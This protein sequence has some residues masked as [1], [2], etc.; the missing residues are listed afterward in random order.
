MLFR[1]IYTQQPYG[2][3]V[4]VY[5]SVNYGEPSSSHSQQSMQYDSLHTPVSILDHHQHYSP[6][7]VFPPQL[8]Q[9]PQ[10]ESPVVYDQEPYGQQNLADLLGELKMDETG[11]G[12]FRLGSYPLK[13]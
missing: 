10:A 6:N 9:N 2:D 8:P 3:T 13:Y 11:T 4:G 5:Q 12:M 1:S 7:H